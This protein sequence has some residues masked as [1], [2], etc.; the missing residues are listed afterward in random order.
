MRSGELCKMRP[1]DIDR[2]SEVWFYKPKSACEKQ[3]D[4]KT[5]Y[6]GHVKIIP[7]GPKAQTILA[8][9]L[10]RDSTEFCFKP[11]ESYKQHLQRKS[12]KRETPLSCGNRPGSNRKGNRKFKP[13]YDA[14]TYQKAIKRACKILWP[15]PD[16]FSKEQK[17]QW[18][19]EHSWHPHQLRHNAAT[20]IRKEFGLD[21][22]RAVLGHKNLSITDDYAELDL[23]KAKEVARLIG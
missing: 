5:E 7:I 22:A 20:E 13:C 17:K 1:C 3:Y 18:H 6:L 15:A 21:A 8:K 2:S 16:D 14:D 12:D 4:H 9:Y 10:L 23:E 19:K 11:E